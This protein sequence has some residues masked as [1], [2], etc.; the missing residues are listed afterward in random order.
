MRLPAPF[1]TLL[2]A[3]LLATS[4]TAAAQSAPCLTRPDKLTAA[5]SASDALRWAQG[6][7]T[8]ADSDSTLT[9][10]LTTGSVDAAGRSTGW[11]LELW[12]SSG[13][14]FHVVVFGAGAMTCMTN[15][16]EGPM[17]AEPVNESSATIFDL[18]RLVGIA[19]EASNPKPDLKR[20]KVSASLQRNADDSAARW[21]I[22]FVDAQGYPKGQVTIDSITGDV[23]K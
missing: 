17:M 13:K 7:A 4:A 14:R 19:L 3:V 8:T 23:V 15:A 5:L 6:E 20:L 22:S 10:M 16:H 21:S 2:G 12:S 11:M 1:L 18:R 9:R